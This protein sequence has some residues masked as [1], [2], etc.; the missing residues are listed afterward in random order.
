MH[1]ACVFDRPEIKGDTQLV[2]CSLE[3]LAHEALILAFAQ[4]DIN[5]MVASDLSQWIV[6]ETCEA[7]F[8][9]PHRGR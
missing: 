4:G 1:P 2:G 7:S 9:L 5:T 3:V 8:G 6:D